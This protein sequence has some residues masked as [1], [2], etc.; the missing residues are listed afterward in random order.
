MKKLLTTAL[1]SGA[2]LSSAT[3]ASAAPV[4]YIF[5][6]YHTNIH[7]HAN[8]LGFSTV[9]GKFAKVEG[10]VVLDAEKPETSTVEATIYTDSVITGIEK[11]DTHLKSKDFFNSE[12]FKVATFK[13]TKVELSKDSA[14]P[15]AK[16]HGTLSLLGVSKPIT[17]DVSLN[18]IAL[19]PFNNENTA[20]FS[21]GT[22]IK[23]SDFGMNYALPNVSNDVWVT[24]EIEAI[25]AK[26]KTNTP[27]ATEKKK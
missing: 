3:P 19:N 21:A 4:E 5:D 17:L 10:K 15:K 20:G 7:W 8:H 11:F 12:K 13:S 23:R 26:P 25:A 6:P 1:L 27:A 14:E 18:K 24:L 2:L 9:A 16:V 22:N